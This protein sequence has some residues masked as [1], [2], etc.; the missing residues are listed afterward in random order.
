MRLLTDEERTEVL[1]DLA[2]NATYGNGLI[3]IAKAQDTKTLKAV[4]EWLDKLPCGEEQYTDGLYYFRIMI[5]SS[6]L[7]LL[8]K[9]EMPG[10]D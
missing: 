4:G 2:E 6:D 10:E 7:E 1:N 9:G 5:K 8:L 3:A